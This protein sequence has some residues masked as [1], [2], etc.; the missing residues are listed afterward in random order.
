MI[1]QV[2]DQKREKTRRKK[3]SVCFTFNFFLFFTLPFKSWVEV[4]QN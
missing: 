3:E 4:V 1:K 2:K